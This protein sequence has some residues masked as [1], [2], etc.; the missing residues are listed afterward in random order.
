MNENASDQEK[1]GAEAF[2]SYMLTE[3]VQQKM[4]DTMG[5]ALGATDAPFSAATDA[6]APWL[7]DFTSTP[8]S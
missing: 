8:A 2:L 7:T 4:V 5:G 3:K 1:A 6:S